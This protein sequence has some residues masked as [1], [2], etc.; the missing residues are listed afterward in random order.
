MCRGRHEEAEIVW[1]N[2]GHDHG[3]GG[4]ED[5]EGKLSVALFMMTM[6]KKIWI[7][8]SLMM[9]MKNKIMKKR[10]KMMN[11]KNKMKKRKN[12]MM[13]NEA[14]DEKRNVMF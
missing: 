12:K 8:I 6:S 4:Q 2:D 5:D 9:K 7:N 14:I 1:D 10:N 13:K 11:T 3:G